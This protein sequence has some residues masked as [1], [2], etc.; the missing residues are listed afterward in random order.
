MYCFLL[1]PASVGVK[2]LSG[3]TLNQTLY[4][5]QAA[6]GFSF[7]DPEAKCGSQL[8]YFLTNRDGD[9]PEAQC[10]SQ[11]SYFLTNRDGDNP[12]A[13]CGSPVSYLLT[14]WME[15]V[16]KHSVERKRMCSGGWGM[17]SWWN[18]HQ[19]TSSQLRSREISQGDGQRVFKELHLGRLTRIGSDPQATRS[20][21]LEKHPTSNSRYSTYF[22]LFCQSTG[23]HEPHLVRPMA[24]SRLIEHCGQQAHRASLAS[25][26]RGT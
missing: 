16:Q 10:G 6:I 19:V 23:L 25:T 26:L 14:N 11:L 8:S 22:R 2:P 15:T 13:Q 4:E 21:Q 12:E 3:E 20:N 18:S 9:N 24:I 5:K 1:F 17:V 7:I